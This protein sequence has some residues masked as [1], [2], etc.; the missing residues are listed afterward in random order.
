M[1]RGGRAALQRLKDPLENRADPAGSISRPGPRG[2]DEL[3][4]SWVPPPGGFRRDSPRR[5]TDRS[6]RYRGR[7]A[8]GGGRVIRD[9]RPTAAA[10]DNFPGLCLLHRCPRF[11]QPSSRL[12]CLNCPRGFGDQSRL[13]APGGSVAPADRKDTSP[14]PRSVDSGA[15]R[16]FFAAP[17]PQPLRRPPGSPARLPARPAG[18]CLESLRGNASIGR[19]GPC[20]CG[21]NAVP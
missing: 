2:S 9:E 8:N 16:A 11:L 21:L 18:V 19:P 14:N 7:A 3:P 6:I 20:A 12:V 17:I 10:P 4:G 5:A 15:S 13:P 1:R